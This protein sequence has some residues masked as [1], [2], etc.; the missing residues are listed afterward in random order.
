MLAGINKVLYLYQAGL[1]SSK[2]I[3]RTC[4][5]T[6]YIRRDL[7][8]LRYILYRYDTSGGSNRDRL[9]GVLHRKKLL[10]LSMRTAFIGIIGDN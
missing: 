5:V 1:E 9:K 8:N 10:P 4:I 7:Y 3:S 2:L 6:R